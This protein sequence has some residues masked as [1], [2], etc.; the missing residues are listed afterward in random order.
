MRETPLEENEAGVLFIFTDLSCSPAVELEQGLLTEFF[1]K[2]YLV[3][4]MYISDNEGDLGKLTDHVERPLSECYRKQ[5]SAC[6][7][8]YPICG[9]GLYGTTGTRL[10]GEA[11][12]MQTCTS[13]SETQSNLSTLGE[14]FAIPCTGLSHFRHPPAGH[15]AYHNHQRH[16]LFLCVGIL[17]QNSP[18]THPAGHR[19][20]P[21]G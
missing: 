21:L 8:A 20:H 14:E 15:S 19:Q 4:F 10:A 9:L 6:S 7:Q 3:R 2:G 18:G 13:N 1:V 17:S 5:F 12:G 11:N 16:R